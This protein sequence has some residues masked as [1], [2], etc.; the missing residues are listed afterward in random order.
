MVELDRET[1]PL[2]FDLLVTATDMDGNQVDRNSGTA[3][4]I[5]N[6]ESLCKIILANNLPMEQTIIAS[7][8]FSIL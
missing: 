2:P 4:V 6:S 3:R 5:I 1:R 7:T 8:E